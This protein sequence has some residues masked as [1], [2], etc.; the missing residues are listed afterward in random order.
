MCGMFFPVVRHVSRSWYSGPTGRTGGPPNTCLQKYVSRVP[1]HVPFG[2][3]TWPSSGPSFSN[4]RS[5]IPSV[6]SFFP[7][8]FPLDLSW[9]G[10]GRRPSF[11]FLALIASPHALSPIGQ[12]GLVVVNDEEPPSQQ[13]LTEASSLLRRV[14]RWGTFTFGNH[15]S[16]RW[17]TVQLLQPRCPA[18]PS[19]QTHPSNLRHLELGIGSFNAAMSVSLL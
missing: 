13:A 15:P 9:H 5:Y 12:L 11:R 10:L 4:D 19:L 18:T 17:Y 1:A 3:H 6:S 2:G 14:R 7:V 16:L 8:F